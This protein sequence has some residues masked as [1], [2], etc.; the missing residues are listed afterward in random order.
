MA[1]LV[2]LGGLL[3]SIVGGNTTAAG[4][5]VIGRHTQ[6]GLAWVAAA[7]LIL[8]IIK[9]EIRRRGIVAPDCRFSGRAIRGSYRRVKVK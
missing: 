4:F 2:A 1:S 9:I 6:E 3:L 8:V 5:G 7:V